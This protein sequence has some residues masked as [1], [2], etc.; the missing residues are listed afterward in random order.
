MSL[1]TVSSPQVRLFMTVSPSAAL[2][3]APVRPQMP[4][5][6]EAAIVNSLPSCCNQH[7]HCRIVN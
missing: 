4:D 2:L 7:F 5:N 6:S 1:F 3:Q